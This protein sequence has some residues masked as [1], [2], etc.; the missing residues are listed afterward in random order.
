[1][2]NPNLSLR[3]EQAVIGALLQDPTA[4]EEI[5][6]L[7][8]DRFTHPTYREVFAELD[9]SGAVR[10]AE[11]PERIADRLKLPGVDATYLRNLAANCPEPADIAVYA[12]M[13]QE[14]YVRSQLASHVDRIA[15]SAGTVRGADP[16]LDHLDRLAQ[17]LARQAAPSHIEVQLEAAPATYQPTV[18]EV[19]TTVVVDDRRQR[20]ELVLAD[21]LQHGEQVAEVEVWLS[22]GS[23]EP[24]PR[25]EVYEAILAVYAQGEPVNE[26]TVAWELGRHTA[27]VVYANEVEVYQEPAGPAYLAHLMATAVVVG[28]AMEV[29]H[30]LF[31]EDLRTDLAHDASR[32]GAQA[33]E[34]ERA[35]SSA[36]QEL[37]QVQN[38]RPAPQHDSS[39]FQTHGSLQ[40]PP[41]QPL[42][43]NQPTIRP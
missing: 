17:A 38:A 42:P 41:A 8:A 23:F 2:T 15:A 32:I 14:T 26:L 33:A 12:R 29:G 7:K 22:P 16:K 24:G 6:Y 3:A 37:T 39:L 13:M 20:E 43:D 11:L 9:N 30:E 4:R 10:A 19:E 36:R 34:G 28:V 21:L 5:A 1:M 40:P 18:V 25:R 31:V 35:E 27:T